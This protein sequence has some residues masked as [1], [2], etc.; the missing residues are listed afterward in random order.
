FEASTGAHQL[1]RDQVQLVTARPGNCVVTSPGPLCSTA[2]RGAIA[3][4][5]R[6]VRRKAGR[7]LSGYRLQG[8]R[9]ERGLLGDRPTVVVLHRGRL[10]TGEFR[11]RP[12]RTPHNALTESGAPGKRATT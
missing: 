5:P 4:S 2:G 1:I 9:S 8:G 6:P 10:G 7:L 12:F 3:G 11:C